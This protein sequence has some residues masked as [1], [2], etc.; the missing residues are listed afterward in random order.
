[1]DVRR[2]LLLNRSSEDSLP[3]HAIH[4][5][6]SMARSRTASV[7][8]DDAS[9]IGPAKELDNLAGPLH[10]GALLLRVHAQMQMQMPPTAQSMN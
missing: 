3:R 9:F 6:S 8:N 10:V 4:A 5:R 7:A 2:R 1:M